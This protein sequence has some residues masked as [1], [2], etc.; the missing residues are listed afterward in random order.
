MSNR[1]ICICGQPYNHHNVFKC[2]NGSIRNAPNEKKMSNEEFP[3]SNK[4]GLKA[5]YKLEQGYGHYV[6]NGEAVFKAKDVETLFQSAQVLYRSK[7]GLWTHDDYDDDTHKGLLIGVEPIKKKTKAEAALEFVEKC[8][9]DIFTMRVD[10]LVT[11][12]KRI[13][14][15]KDEE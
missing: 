13:L 6:F 3:I 11:E 9:D 2:M 12:A 4:L 1:D 8:R 14:E 10:D 5:I 15:M 7:D